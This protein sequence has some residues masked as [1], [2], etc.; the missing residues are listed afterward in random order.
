[1]EILLAVAAVAA[2][3][4]LARRGYLDPWDYAVAAGI[5]LTLAA[6]LL[7]A[8]PDETQVLVLEQLGAPRTTLAGAD[9]MMTHGRTIVLSLVVF[10]VGF[11][12]DA[13]ARRHRP[14]PHSM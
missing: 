9:F 13:L 1:M 7:I 11:F 6:T 10:A 2:G 8:I 14:S 4:V 12:G 5:A 3:L